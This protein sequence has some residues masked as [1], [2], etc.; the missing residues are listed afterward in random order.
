MAELI[1]SLVLKQGQE[2]HWQL[3]QRPFTLVY[4][5][6]VQVQNSLGWSLQAPSPSSMFFDQVSEELNATLLGDFHS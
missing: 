2:S 4:D 1:D 5:M 3:N 6:Q